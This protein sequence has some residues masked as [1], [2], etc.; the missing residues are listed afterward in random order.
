M[1][2]SPVSL[3]ELEKA[4]DDLLMYD[5]PPYLADDDITV[6][7][8]VRHAKYGP[9]KARRMLNDWTEAGKVEYIGKRREPRGH[10]VDAWRV[11][12]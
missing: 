5:A 2:N 4:L 11:K 9:N 3:S 1:A 6:M 10:M 8:L 7:R 12:S